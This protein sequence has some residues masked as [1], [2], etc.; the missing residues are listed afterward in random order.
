MFTFLLTRDPKLQ[1]FC[2]LDHVI[3][4]P[5]LGLLKDFLL[6]VV[7]VRSNIMW[8]TEPLLSSDSVNRG[9]CY[10]TPAT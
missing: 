7:F 10:V 1:I 4:Y 5:P 2:A 8:G 3:H 6:Y 9:R